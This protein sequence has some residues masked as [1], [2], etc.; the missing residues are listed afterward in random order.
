[1]NKRKSI[2]FYSLLPPLGIDYA[3]L[4]FFAP[5]ALPILIGNVLINT[6]YLFVIVLLV[7]FFTKN[8]AKLSIKLILGISL[9]TTLAQDL[10]NLFIG[11]FIYSDPSTNLHP[12]FSYAL[13][14]LLYN[15]I[16]QILFPGVICFLVLLYFLG[17]KKISNLIVVALLISILN[18]S[19]LSYMLLIKPGKPTDINTNYSQKQV[20]QLKDQTSFN[21]IDEKLV[22]DSRTNGK[23]KSL[24]IKT[25]LNV[26]Q[27]GTYTIRPVLV[28][29]N[30]RGSNLFYDGPYDYYI[31]GNLIGVLGDLKLTKAKNILT[32][33]FPYVSTQQGKEVVN[34]KF[35]DRVDGTYGPYFFKII[36][37]DLKTN[38]GRV[39]INYSSNDYQTKTYKSQDFYNK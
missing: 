23:Y 1:M 26:P 21:V 17:K 10:Y 15:V 2:V 39:E 6:V 4:S 34:L 16:T 25:E 29:E 9:I 3:L 12:L 11:P 36:L 14:P 35:K 19:W 33:N 20:S 38:E 5:A 13:T 8:S 27:D 18:L 32:F 30:K 24:E 22:P 28:L 31:N 37:S 7:L